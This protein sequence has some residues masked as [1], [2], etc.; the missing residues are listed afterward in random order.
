PGLFNARNLPFQA[1]TVGTYGGLDREQTLRMITLSNAQL[2]GI[3]ARVG[4]IEVGK[5]A[6]FFLSRGDALDMRTNALTRAFI[7]GREIDLHGTQQVLYER[8]KRKYGGGD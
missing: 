6:T 2:L 4:S 8:Y 3:D 7:D 5:D 1:A